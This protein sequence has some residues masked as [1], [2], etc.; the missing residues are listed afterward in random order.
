MFFD[1]GRVAG[2]VTEPP[3]GRAEL[4][5]LMRDWLPGGDAV[6]RRYQAVSACHGRFSGVSFRALRGSLHPL[7]GPENKQ[8]RSLVLKFIEY[9]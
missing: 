7:K 3:A 5:G 4:A 6:A 9:V 2:F 1:P 8:N